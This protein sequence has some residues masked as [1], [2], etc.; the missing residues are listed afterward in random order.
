MLKFGGKIIPIFY[1]V[2][3]SDLRWLHQGKRIYI[4]AFKKHERNGKCS[5]EQLQEWKSALH[6]VSFYASQIVNTKENEMRLLKN[7]ASCVLKEINNNVPLVVAKYLVGLKDIV[8]EFKV[9]ALSSAHGNQGIQIIGIW[10]IGGSGK[11]TLAKELLG[12]TME[13]EW[14]V[15]GQGEGVGFES[16][17]VKGGGFRVRFPVGWSP[18]HP[19]F[20]G[21]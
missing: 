1:H 2:D 5:P 20:L 3:P 18:T 19:D 14:L 13:K 15:V 7:I 11:T 16:K 4:E 21:A 9:N 12:G 8:D 6:K 17:G 10:G